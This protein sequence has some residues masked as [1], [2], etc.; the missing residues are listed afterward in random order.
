MEE[1]KARLLA[2]RKHIEAKLYEMKADLEGA[3]VDVKRDL[4]RRLKSLEGHFKD[5]WETVEQKWDEVNDEL[6]QRVRDWL[7][8]DDQH[9]QEKSSQDKS[10]GVG[11][12]KR[13][14]ATSEIL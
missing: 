4:E 12:A 7:K 2:K 10:S 5:G 3:K 13:K 1:L 8:E 6:R 14:L 11:E 9:D